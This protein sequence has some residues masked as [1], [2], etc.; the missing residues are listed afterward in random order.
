MI[1]V[2]VILLT[3]AAS[4]AIVAVIAKSGAADAAELRKWSG[5]HK[6]QA[7][8]AFLCL[9]S[10]VLHGST[11]YFSWGDF[12][13]GKMEDG[14]QKSWV[15]NDVVHIEWVAD[16]LPPDDTIFVAA[17]QY[18]SAEDFVDIAGVSAAVGTGWLEF[19][20][21]NATNFQYFVYSMYVPPSPVVTNGVFHLSGILGGNS[22]EANTT[23]Y[24]PVKFSIFVRDDDGRIKR[25]APIADAEFTEE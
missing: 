17:K 19:T 24:V 16:K 25:I 1:D 13:A 3:F 8:I 11:K 14:E 23:N 20:K 10:A 21:P 2:I 18:G 7:F 4:I 5:K 6:F 22:Y 15:T 12:L 9:F